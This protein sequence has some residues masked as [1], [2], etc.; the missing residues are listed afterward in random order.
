MLLK[1]SDMSMTKNKLRK[2]MQTVRN[3]IPLELREELSMRIH[4]R[5]YADDDWRA[6]GTVLLYCSCRSEVL[7]TALIEH[8]L[9]LKKHVLVPCIPDERN[10]MIAVQIR[11]FEDISEVC[12][13]GMMQ[14]KKELCTP[15]D[16]QIDLIVLPGMVFDRSGSRIGSGNG[17]FDQFLLKYPQAVKAGLAFS[18]QITPHITEEVH[19]IRMHKLFTEHEVIQIERSAQT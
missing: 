4:E 19:D 13:Y 9:Q 10:E 16:G 5:L 12:R 2:E 11:A 8:A 6:A 14:P 17:Y 18:C 7:T 1:I 15:F 3:C